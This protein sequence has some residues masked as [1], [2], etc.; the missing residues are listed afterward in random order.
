MP[1]FLNPWP[2]VQTDNRR[3]KLRNR[4]DLFGIIYSH[5]AP[6][7]VSYRKASS[8]FSLIIVFDF[9][10][11]L[12]IW[13]SLWSTLCCHR[14][15]KTQVR[16]SPTSK[17]IQLWP[18]PGKSIGRLFFTFFSLTSS[19]ISS[20]SSFFIIV[21]I[22][23]TTRIIFGSFSSSS[24]QEILNL[25]RCYIRLSSCRCN[26]QRGCCKSPIDGCSTWNCSS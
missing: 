19:S 21:D 23:L 15:T 17:T 6:T 18:T 10:S 20:L 2:L 26:T 11:K 7:I 14:R 9:L 22:S 3:L 8:N 1:S 13:L 24:L 16:L 4:E 5:L 12:G 25:V